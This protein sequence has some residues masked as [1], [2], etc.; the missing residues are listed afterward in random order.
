MEAVGKTISWSP[1]AGKYSL[2]LADGEGK[3]LD[4]VCFE[5]RGPEIDRNRLSEG[6]R[7]GFSR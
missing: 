2:A 6:E 5:V 3:I 4:F 1:R 7:R